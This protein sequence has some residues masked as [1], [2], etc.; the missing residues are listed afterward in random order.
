MLCYLTISHSDALF[1]F[2]PQSFLADLNT[3]TQLCLQLLHTLT[4]QLNELINSFCCLL[5]FELEFFCYCNL[6]SIEEY[7]ILRSLC[8][9]SSFILIEF[10]SP[11][12]DKFVWQLLEFGEVAALTLVF[13]ITPGPCL[14]GEP[15]WPRKVKRRRRN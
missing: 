13:G 9:F 3:Q 2:C 5:L 12:P 6:K 7:G 10:R 11:S 8:L 14:E 1:S 4:F 15:L